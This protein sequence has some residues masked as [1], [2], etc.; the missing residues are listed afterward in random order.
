MTKK[1]LIVGHGFVG[2]AVESV[3]RTE[4]IQISIIDPKYKTKV[5]DY[6]DTNPV[7]IFICVPTPSKD[8]G[9]QDNKI[10]KKVYLTLI[11]HFFS[12]IQIII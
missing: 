2:Q 4:K 5:D 10:L 1:D 3:L 11:I 9:S 12:S 6:L 8:D 7:Y